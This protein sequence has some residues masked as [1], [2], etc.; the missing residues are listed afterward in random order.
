MSE[1][2]IVIAGGSD[3]DNNMEAFGDYF[4]TIL[5]MKEDLINLGCEPPFTIKTIEYLKRDAQS[6][7]HALFLLMDYEN[8]ELQGRM[9]EVIKG[10]KVRVYF[11][12]LDYILAQDY[13][14]EWIIDES[15]QFY[16]KDKISYP[17]IILT[18][19]IKSIR[20]GS[21]TIT[22]FEKYED[23][24]EAMRGKQK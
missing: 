7:N 15:L 20:T 8:L 17:R 13:I 16:E 12:E 3:E 9:L 6:N 11:N 22:G 18:D 21:L 14:K 2:I 19:G 24:W 1:D 23:N 4:H 10:E 5:H